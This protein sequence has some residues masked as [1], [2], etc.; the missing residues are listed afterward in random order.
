LSGTEITMRKVR[1]VDDEGRV[2]VVEDGKTE[3]RNARVDIPLV[4]Q[5]LIRRLTEGR[6]ANEYLFA[7]KDG[8]PHWRDWP[9]ENVKRICRLA[10]VQPV[11]GHAMRGLH[12]SMLLRRG[13]S[14]RQ[15]ADALRHA[16]ESTTIE[17]YA[18]SNA[19]RAGQQ[20]VVTA[21][22]DGAY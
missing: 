9:S 18:D 10:G 15:A 1:D 5:P 8:G 22:L 17:S 11:C 20:A 4:L 21:V 12:A 7:A 14:P 19:V 16:H 6:Q 3:N 13:A 2:L